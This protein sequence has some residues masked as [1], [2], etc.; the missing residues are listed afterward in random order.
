MQ[1]DLMLIESNG[2]SKR[3]GYIVKQLKYMPLLI[4]EMWG[5]K[6]VSKAVLTGAPACAWK[7][8]NTTSSAY[9]LKKIR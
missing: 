6:E 7:Y 5:K 2:E 4:L 9:A 3:V 8:A 1:K